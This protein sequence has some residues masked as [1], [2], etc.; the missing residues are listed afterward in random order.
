MRAKSF[1]DKDIY[2]FPTLAQGV[3]EKCAGAVRLWP[4][5]EETFLHFLERSRVT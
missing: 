1:S 5:T 2:A 4:P 3:Q